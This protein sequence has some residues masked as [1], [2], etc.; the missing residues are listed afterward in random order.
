MNAAP[1][2][3][4]PRIVA[5]HGVG[6]HQ[7]RKAPEAVRAEHIGHWTRH[8]AEG[9]GVEPALLSLDFAHYAHLLHT[10]PVAQGQ[11]ATDNLRDPLAQELMTQWLTE[12]GAPEPIAQGKLTR[13]LRKSATW[14]AERF[15]LDGSPTEHFVRLLFPE[16]AAYLRAD[17]APARLA[18]REEVAG[19][20][21]A[22]RP[23]VVVAHSLGTVVTYEALHAHPE[24]EVD[25][26]LTLGS[27]L[28][29][30]H[31]VFPR[32]TPRPEA[33]TPRPRGQRPPG[34][35]R[36]VNIADPGDPVAIPPGLDRAFHGVD[37]DITTTIHAAF[38]FH[39][40]KNYLRCA[41]TAGQLAPFLTRAAIPGRRAVS[42]ETGELAPGAAPTSG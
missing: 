8:L 23:Q 10:G 27:P 39:H 33:G 26:L 4:A 29:L 5:V 24:L 41:P 15:D 7:R 22:H 1:D 40:A 6:Y 30:P 35:K 19:R 42:D 12:L 9:L 20:I 3:S 11:N 28:A 34:V 14:V 36:W 38:G 18:V 21:A 16:V 37:L 2:V 17:D 25:L 13:P 32:L 31:A